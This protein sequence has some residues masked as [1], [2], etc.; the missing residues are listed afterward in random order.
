MQEKNISE[1][2]FEQCIKCTICTVYCP[3]VPVNP[4]FPGPKH[5]G[6]DGERLRLKKVSF[7]DDTLKYCLN[8]KICEV[9]CPSGVKI[10]D[11][12]QTARIKHN[13]SLPKLR[14]VIL[15][16]TDLMGTVATKMAPIVNTTLGLKPVKLVM[17]G[18]L[19]IDHHRTFPKYTSKT[20]ES[21]YKKNVAAEQASYKN[22][23]SYF[24]GCSA[25]YNH[26]EF[27]RDLITVMNAIGYGVHLLDKEKCCGVA[28]I[29][30]GLINQ[31]KRNAKHNIKIIEK[32]VELVE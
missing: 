7:F 14:D 17:D 11:I 20:F 6:P 8:C 2:N 10:G 22:H 5:A 28:L 30:N 27:G 18:V 12:I 4:N 29:S 1:N 31:A 13:Q 9:A 15:A 16:N 26:P 23:I 21:W 25:N 3:V 32:S 19:G 24:H